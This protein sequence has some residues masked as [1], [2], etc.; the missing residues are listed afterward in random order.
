MTVWTRTTCRLLIALMI[1]TPWQVTQAGMIGAGDS[2]AAA[3]SSSDRAAVLAL[4]SRADVAREL[5]A[6]GVDPVL[7]AE[8]VA[9]MS[10]QELKSVADRIRGLPAGGNIGGIIAWAAVILLIWYIFW[11]QYKKS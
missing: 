3:S 1:W 2:A 8:R 9:A 6:H 7:A 4:I 5:Q 10:D 11:G